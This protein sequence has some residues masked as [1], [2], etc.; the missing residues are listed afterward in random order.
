MIE[1]RSLSV[2]LRTQLFLAV[3]PVHR[4]TRCALAPPQ[5]WLVQLRTYLPFCRPGL[6]HPLR[7]AIPGGPVSRPLPS[8]PRRAAHKA[9]NRLHAHTPLPSRDS[10]PG[11][12]CAPA[13]RARLPSTPSLAEA[14][15]RTR[16]ARKPP[17]SSTRLSYPASNCGGA[18][19]GSRVSWGLLRGRKHACV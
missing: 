19:G 12:T 14:S 15:R 16:A 8:A 3:L 10:C 1:M 9:R 2:F 11:A 6:P 5:L 7:P 17:G 4:C 18:R 13:G